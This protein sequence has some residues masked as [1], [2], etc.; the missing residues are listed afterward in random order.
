MRIVVTAAD[1]QAGVDLVTGATPSAYL[2]LLNKPDG[3]VYKQPVLSPQ[4]AVTALQPLLT[5]STT[6]QYLS[7]A[8]AY[9]ESS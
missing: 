3:R 5:A 8:P 1:V 7:A 4:N 2:Q 6:T 9:P